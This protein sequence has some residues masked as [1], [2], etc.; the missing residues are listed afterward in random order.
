MK[1]LHAKS[2][3]A[4]LSLPLVLGLLVSSPAQARPKAP[5]LPPPPVFTNASVHDPDVIKADGQYYAFGSHL[6]AA[7]SPDLMQWKQVANGVNPSNPLFDDVTTELKEALEWAQS[8]TLWAPDVIQLADGRFYMYYD[9]CKGDSPRSALGEAVADKVTGPYED[10]G[11]L[12][13][14]GMWDQPSED[15]EI[16]DARVHPNTVDPDVF[17]DAQGKLW[18]VYGSFSGGIF[19]LGLDPSTGLPFPDQ[20]YGKHLM[21]GNHARI[22]GPAVMYNP[23]T[24]YYYLFTTFGG[25]DADGG[26]NIRVSR[27]RNPD[28]PYRDASGTDMATV[29]SDP[30]KPLFDDASIEPHGTKLMGNHL[31]QREVGDPGSGIGTGYVSPG[32]VSPIYD[33]ATGRQLLTMHARFPGRGEE[34]EIRVHQMY[35]NARG[36]PVVAPHRYAGESLRKVKRKDIVGTYAY[37]NHG[38]AISADI[39]RS[40]DIRLR[41]NGKITGAVRGT[42]R[43]TGRNEARLTIDGRRYATVFSRQWEPTS[44]SWVVTFSGLSRKGVAVWGSQRSLVSHR[45]V[46]ARVVADLDLPA[47]AIADLTLPTV[48]SQGSTIAWTSSDPSVIS[49]T[50]E[51][52]RPAAG[53]PDATVTLTARIT[54]GPVSRTKTFTVTVLAKPVGGLVAHYAFDGTLSSEG[55]AAAGVVTGDRIDRTGGTL[56]YTAG[57][58][59]QAAVFDGQS[60]VR[61]PDGLI[62]G[63][64]YAVSLWLKPSELNAFTT[65]FFGAKDPNSWVSLLPK[66]HAGVNGNTMLWSGT[67]WYDADTGTQIPVGEW[68]HLA[69]SNED[70]HLVVWINGRRVVDRTGFPDVFTTTTGTFSLAVNWW[71][72][73][74]KGQMDD[75]RVYNSPLT[76]ADVTALA[77]R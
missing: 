48:G 62:E 54:S 18:M 39:T 35:T 50:G 59:G 1:L 61:L 43:R 7:S 47:T 66:G 53:A 67:A 3:S 37:L 16:Y 24:E 57:V 27:S 30:D 4:M 31:F 41:A 9:A 42:W 77:E 6:A 29:K 36:W 23:E 38:K 34:H 33:E 13:K 25:L 26:Y 72:A 20:G 60:G 17:Y 70:G 68:S 63:S 8:D 14:S 40:S 15:G 21:G 10:L 56:T 71:D 76:D 5:A 2:W 49:P 28:G 64:N 74:Y 11:I 52:T 65:T 19:I 45:E 51:V 73:P 69:F 46:V 12:L 32:G 55:S 22:E 58:R 75:L 44:G